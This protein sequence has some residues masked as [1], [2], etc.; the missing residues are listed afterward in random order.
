M[1][2]ASRDFRRIGQLVFICIPVYLNVD[3]FFAI[4]VGCQSILITRFLPMLNA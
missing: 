2:C 3:P 4:V 1:V